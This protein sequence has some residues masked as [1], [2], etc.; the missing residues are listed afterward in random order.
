[1]RPLQAQEYERI[2]GFI[3]DHCGIRL[4]VAKQALVSSRL[5]R[6]IEELGL[7]TF[8]NYLDAVVADRSGNLLAA[9]TDLLTTNFTSFF[10]ETAHF[11]FLADVL[12]RLGKRKEEIRIWSA[13]CSSGEEPYSIAMA[14]AER[15]ISAKVAIEASDISTRV[16]EK[17]RQGVYAINAVANL[18]PQMRRKYFL[19]GSGQSEGLCRV[20][21]E[22]RSEVA[23]EQVNL[24]QPFK[25]RH[26][27]DMIW[28]RN[29]MIY[30]D[31]AT[32]ERV[33]ERLS[34]W[35]KPAG[36][37][38]IGHSEALSGM[39]HTLQYVQPA[40]YQRGK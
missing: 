8:S 9:M 27:Y 23:F 28:C 39:N 36:F 4:G 2:S 5:T 20:M 32:Q 1:M 22:I 6:Q 21:P 37:L 34:Q 26:K 7:N 16:L 14:A 33:V 15:E 19:K 12:D 18:E 29:V 17:A 30:F 3:Y 24:T 11:V 13:A 10:R 40:V 38:L 25:R 31:K 35:L